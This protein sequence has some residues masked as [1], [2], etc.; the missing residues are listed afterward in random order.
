MIV[1]I[2]EEKGFGKIQYAFKAEVLDRVGQER[3]YLNIWRLFMANPQP[4]L[5]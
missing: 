1:S 4:A 3:T 2:K 5:S